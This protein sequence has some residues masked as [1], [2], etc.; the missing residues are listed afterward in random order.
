MDQESIED[1]LNELLEGAEDELDQVFLSRLKEMEKWLSALFKRYPDPETNSINRSEIYKLRRFDKEMQFIKQ[2]IQ[3][4]Y[5]QA[6]ALIFGL[7]SSQYVENHLRSGYVYEMTTQTEM[8]FA[9]PN[10]ETIR[11]AVMNP[12]KEIRLNTTLNGHRNA[13]IKKIRTEIAQGIGAGESYS[14][15]AKRLEEISG[16]SRRKARMTARTEAG[17]S[18]SLGRLRSIEKAKEYMPETKTDEAWLSSRDASV[19]H[20]HRVLDGQRKG[21]DGLFEYQGHKARA[22]SLFGVAKLDIQCRCDTLLLINGEKPDT[23]RVR[24]YDDEDYQRRLAER[25]KEIMADEGKTEKQATRKAKR[26]IYPPSKV[27]EFMDY[28]AWYDSL[29]NKG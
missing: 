6:Y 4:D 13:V 21:D 7:M 25:I 9:I 15:M 12:I 22:P 28:Q 14:T 8:Q 19:R 2:N 29:L 17:R 24:D 20:A 27:Q 23:M 5:K 11:E 16:F 3:E 1:Y 26:Q 18:Q 10:V